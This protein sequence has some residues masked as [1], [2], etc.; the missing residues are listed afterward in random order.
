MSVNITY[1]HQKHVLETMIG[2]QS[3]SPICDCRGSIR[4]LEKDETR[5]ELGKLADLWLS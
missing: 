1:I 5:N 4:T 2:V 3:A